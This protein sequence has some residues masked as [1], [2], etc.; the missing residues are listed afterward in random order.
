MEWGA[1]PT[2]SKN[3]DNIFV[4]ASFI[5]RCFESLDRL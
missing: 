4:P 2:M 1:E 3:V 5:T